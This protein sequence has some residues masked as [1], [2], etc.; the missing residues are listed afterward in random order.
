ME[1]PLKSGLYPALHILY[2][3]NISLFR[4]LRLITVQYIAT[5]MLSP[6]LSS[7]PK[8]SDNIKILLKDFTQRKRIL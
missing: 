5:I 3:L 8:N 6:S 2:I 1:A 7:N 4:Y